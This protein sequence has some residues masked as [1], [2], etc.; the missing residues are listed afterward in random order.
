MKVK[1]KSPLFES[2]A[3]PIVVFEVFFICMCELNIMDMW[4]ISVGMAGFF[5]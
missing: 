2:F 3:F 4:K 1:K 5:K